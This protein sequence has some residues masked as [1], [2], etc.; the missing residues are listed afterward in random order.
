MRLLDRYLLRELLTPLGYCLGGFLVFWVSFNLISDLDDLQREKLKAIEVAHYYLLRTPRLLEEIVLPAALLLALLYTLTNHARHNELTAMRAAGLSLLRLCVPYFGVGLF[1]SASLY[2]LNEHWVPNST[3]LAEQIR[4]RRAADQAG[5]ASRQW[6][7]ELTFRN[8]RDGRLWR[9]LAYNVETGEMREPYVQWTRP[10]GSRQELIAERGLRTNGVWTFY[11]VRQSMPASSP[12]AVVLWQRTNELAVAEFLETP[13]Q[14]KSEIKISRLISQV[15]RIKA[16]R[17]VQ[18]SIAEI[19]DYKRLNPELRPRD[20][21]LLDTQLHARLA[22]PWTCLVVVF[23]AIPFGA[24]S[25]RRN[26]FV[27]VA[28]SILIFFGY[29]V[30]QQIGMAVGTG[31]Y[32]PPLL[33]AWLPN[34]AFGGA[35]FWFT[36]RVR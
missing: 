12:D 29:F 26:V 30:L 13:E 19:L 5:G 20:R 34:A 8:D 36:L 22:A 1:F 23:I 7:H 14:I 25:G 27:G 17:R 16:A 6:H 24:Q 32:V 4:K 18:L 35:G 10:D 33:A 2:L 11:N 31:Q 15:N 9:I 3:D 21:A 28:S